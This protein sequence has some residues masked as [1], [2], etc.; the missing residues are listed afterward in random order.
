MEKRSNLDIELNRK[1]IQ[2]KS[3]WLGVKAHYSGNFPNDLVG[4]HNFEG[5]YCGVS[6]VEND[7]I[8]ICYLVQYES[9]KK[10][11]NIVDFQENVIFKNKNLEAIFKESNL[12]F[13]WKRNGNGYS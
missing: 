11:K 10:Y 5:G 3:P 8:N 9:F 4:L 6:K 1:F 13:V 12:L 7:V 2:Q